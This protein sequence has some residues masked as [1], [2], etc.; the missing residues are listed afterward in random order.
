MEEKNCRHCSAPIG[1]AARVC[2]QCRS[3]QGWF[4]STRDPRFFLVS[5]FSWL[6]A[7]SLFALLIHHATNE[8]KKKVDIPPEPTCRGQVVVTESSHTIEKRESITRLYVRVLLQNKFNRD[9]SDPVVRVDALGKDGELLD[10]FIRTIYGAN[11]P[12]TS[13]VWFRV[14]DAIAVDPATIVSV[15]ASVQKADCHGAWR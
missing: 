12:A 4:S 11:I 2:P 15:R 8:E 7:V 9:V 1:S 5:M 14:A 13:S 3:H 6:L 10:T